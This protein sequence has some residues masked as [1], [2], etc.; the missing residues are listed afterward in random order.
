M[1]GLD[2]RSHFLGKNN[3]GNDAK[4]IANGWTRAVT[5]VNVRC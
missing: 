2:P 4:V 5:P 3:S 1:R